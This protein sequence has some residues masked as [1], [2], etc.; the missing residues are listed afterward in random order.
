MQ[1]RVKKIP[2]KFSKE[3]SVGAAGLWNGCLG[4]WAAI[5]RENSYMQEFLARLCTLTDILG[6]IPLHEAP[7]PTPVIVPSPLL[8][9]LLAASGSTSVCAASN[10]VES[11]ITTT[12]PPPAAAGPLPP[13][14][15]KSLSVTTSVG[16][17]SV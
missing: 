16:F 6:A 5:R 14:P 2:V 10:L 1:G 4:Q 12:V 17:A 8:L 9:L 11:A 7:P 3:S 13:P 15:P